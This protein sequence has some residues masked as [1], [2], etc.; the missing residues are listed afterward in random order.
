MH[1]LDDMHLLDARMGEFL[2]DQGLRNDADNFAAG[3]QHGVGND[4][5]EPDMTAAKD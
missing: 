2:V 3:G 4:A 1:R 5:H